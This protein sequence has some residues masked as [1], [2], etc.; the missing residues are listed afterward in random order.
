MLGSILGLELRPPRLRH[1]ILAWHFA[2]ADGDGANIAAA[3]ELKGLR[4]Q[5][6]PHINPVGR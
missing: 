3:I 5:K 2:A 1:F 6:I 4:M